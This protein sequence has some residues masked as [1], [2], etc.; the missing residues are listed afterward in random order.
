MLLVSHF[1]FGPAVCLSVSKNMSINFYYFFALEKNFFTPFSIKIWILNNLI[2]LCVTIK[3]NYKIMGGYYALS[4]PLIRARKKKIL[5][6]K[7][8]GALIIIYY[9]LYFF[10]S[11]L[12]I[13]SYFRSLS[14]TF[15]WIMIIV[16]FFCNPY[17][18]YNGNY[19]QDV[20][21]SWQIV[22]W[23]IIGL[24]KYL[25]LVNLM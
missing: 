4:F 15:I 13:E 23:I 20:P 19:R 25:I 17:C 3:R 12:S 21:I 14:V 2:I 9:L 22:N 7:S 8:G 10:V 18:W 24:F 6:S 16:D 5:C 1:S 11:R